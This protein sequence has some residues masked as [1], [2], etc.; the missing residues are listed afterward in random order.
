MTGH[1]QS[2]GRRYTPSK[3][4]LGDLQQYQLHI[5]SMHS[6]D[7]SRCA[8]DY[9]IHCKGKGSNVLHTLH[10]HLG[11]KGHCVWVGGGCPFSFVLLLLFFFSLLILLFFVSAALLFILNNNKYS[12]YS[13]LYI[14]QYNN[15]I[16]IVVPII[17]L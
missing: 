10:H 6:H 2:Q 7:A 14:L 8:L 4:V 3:S 13:F 1:W 17:T 12:P 11:V 5:F 16:I 9:Q 15:I